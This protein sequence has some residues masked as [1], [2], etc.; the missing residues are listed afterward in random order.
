ML[1]TILTVTRYFDSRYLC[2]QQ[3]LLFY[4]GLVP[5]HYHMFSHFMMVLCLFIVIIASLLV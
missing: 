1:V 4:D 5:F 3:M 2:H